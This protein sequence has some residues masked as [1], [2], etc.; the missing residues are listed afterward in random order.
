MP[1]AASSS[2]LANARR[3]PLDPPVMLAEKLAP[4]EFEFACGEFFGAGPK[5]HK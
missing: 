5:C 3:G 2:G 4:S 1:I